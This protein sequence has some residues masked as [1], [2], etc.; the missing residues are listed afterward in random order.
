MS[1][2]VKR[3]VFLAA[4]AAMLV[5]QAYLRFQSDIIQDVAWFIHVANQLLQGKTLYVDII[6]VNPPLG[7]WLIVPIVWL[8]NLF[9]IDSVIA[10]DTTLLLASAA[11]LTLCNRYLKLVN[12]LNANAR[13]LIVAALAFIVLFFPAIYFAEREHF[14]V[15]LFLPWLFLRLADNSSSK[16]G[17]VERILVGLMAGA[18]ICIKP[19]SFFAPA[20]VE[21]VLFLHG[22]SLRKIFA[23]ENISA[24]LFAVIYAGA[25]LR[26]APKFLNEMLALGA[27]A[28][29][30][31]Y[32]Y[33]L[34]VIVF[35]ARWTIPAML[36][37]YLIRNRL[38]VLKHD[39]LIVDG[40]LAATLGFSISYFVQMKGFGYQIVP[41]DILAST[42]SATGAIL[43]WQT[44]RKFSVYSLGAVCIPLFLVFGVPQTYLNSFKG[45]DGIM[46]RN[47]PQAKSI[48][49]ASTR[50]GD[51]FPFVQQRNLIW[52]SRLPTQWLTPYVD[53]KWHGG[54][55]P[56]DDVVRSALEWT[57]T[58]L[59]NFKP[60]IVMIDI[61]D[62]Q[63]YVQSGKFDYVQFWQN[64]KR[65]AEFW[66]HYKLQE[67]TKD[68]AVYSLVTP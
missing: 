56:Q 5:V 42:A 21:L 31:F 65:F 15:L 59:L 26:F 66:S 44:D 64:D 57:V 18:A 39:T 11:V 54:D 23:V 49:I 25:I 4:I 43:L 40:L 68:L 13:M 6:E 62:D 30:P 53:S 27:K 7:M 48:F 52:A 14:M 45:A 63:I 34:Y 33:P 28:Y 19:Q 58:D 22:K 32:G 55:V 24:G 20:M 60:D 50:L 17:T 9:H 2:K 29:V 46:A 51:A 37:A 35:Y 67:T 47:A 36:I 1:I 41:A 16:I 12:I 10:V 3:N 61:S 8:A 38:A